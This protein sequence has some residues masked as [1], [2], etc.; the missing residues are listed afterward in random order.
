MIDFPSTTNKEKQLAP[1]PLTK[2]WVE[3][4][5]KFKMAAKM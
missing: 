1:M 3:L 5:L 2:V 4:S